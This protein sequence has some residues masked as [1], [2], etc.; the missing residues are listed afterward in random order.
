MNTDEGR[1][2]GTHLRK[3]GRFREQI[4]WL[5]IR[6]HSRNSWLFFRFQSVSIRVDPWL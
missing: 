6:D 1:K 5:R 2:T 3:T 4:G